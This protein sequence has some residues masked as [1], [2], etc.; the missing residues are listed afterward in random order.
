MLAGAEG[1]IQ[2]ITSGEGVAFACCFHCLQAV[3]LVVLLLECGTGMQEHAC[4]QRLVKLVPGL[5]QPSRVLLALPLWWLQV[6]LGVTS[7]A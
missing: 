4:K 3:G 1:K 6:H 5:S 2:S 7:L